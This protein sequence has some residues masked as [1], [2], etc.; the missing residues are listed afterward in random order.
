MSAPKPPKMP[1]TMVEKLRR[2]F[3]VTAMTSLLLILVLLLGFINLFALYRS[4]RE[5]MDV[6]ET[7][8]A[9]DGTFPMQEMRPPENRPEERMQEAFPGSPFPGREAF[10]NSREMEMPFRTRYFA[11]WMNEDGTKDHAM[12]DRIV[13]VSETEAA[14]LAKAAFSTGRNSG[15]MSG[16]AY[17]LKETEDFTL[18]VF[19][20]AAETFASASFLLRVSLLIGAA[21]LLM[22]YALVYVLAG[23]A[24]APVVESLEKQ[25]TFISD[26]GHELKT[27][28]S[29]ISAN[30][31]VIE[32]TTEKSEWTASIR[33]QVKRMT[34]LIN[35]LLT[36]SRMEEEQTRTLYTDVDF[37]AAASEVCMTYET[38][39]RSREKELSCSIEDGIHVLGDER[40][41]GQLCTLLL[42]NAVK[43]SSEH[44]VIR[45]K[46]YLDKKSGKA[47]WEVSNPCDEL[48]A[49][50]LDRLFDR[51]YRADASRNSQT[52]GYGIGLSVA[53]AVCENHGGSIHAY[54]DGSSGIC[55]RAKLEAA[56]SSS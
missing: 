56:K 32:I 30:L 6:L 22:M 10:A 9:H 51:F 34:A 50:N 27:P 11:V 43:Y 4:H 7:L 37:S 1:P 39:A 52:G 26:A 44:A 35:N 28:L 15:Y 20:D 5:T 41:L 21:A 36:L 53:K 47:V 54:P 25:K 18:A 42:D 2:K 13:S 38:V 49:G 3:I 12:M 23:R 8:L 55:F 33:R 16:Y 46:L 40:A 24:V 48:P 29:V 14:V 45:A 19:I 17:G 31:D